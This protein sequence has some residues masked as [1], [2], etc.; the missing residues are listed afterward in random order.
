MTPPYPTRN[1][2]LTPP[3][4]FPGKSTYAECTAFSPNGQNLVTGSVDGFI[5]V[6][7]YL[8]GKLRKDLKYQ[9]EENLMSMDQSVI[10]LNFSHDSELLASG[11]TDGKIAIWKL[12]SGICTRRF[13]PAHSQGV[14]SLCFNKEATQILSGSYD[15]SVKIHNVKSGKLVKAFE[16]HTS[17]VNSVMYNPDNTCIISASSDGEVKVTFFSLRLII[18]THLFCR[19]GI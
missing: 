15:H 2:V 6:W 1:F 7:N 18:G 19:S 11:S 16:G 4:Q 13:S 5:E 3:L 12:Q 9:A 8:T 14:T 17:F 10:C